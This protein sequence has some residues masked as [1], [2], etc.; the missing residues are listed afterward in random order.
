MILGHRF[1]LYDR[2][3]L[4]ESI[5]AEG[6]SGVIR[7]TRSIFILTFVIELL[8]AILLSVSFVPLYGWAKGI[9]YAVFHSVSAFCNAGFD[10]I[11][12]SS[13]I[14]LKENFTLMLPLM[15]LIIIGGLGFIVLIEIK[16]Q[17]FKKLSL[18]SKVVLLMTLILIL[19]GTLFF[20]NESHNPETIV[21][22][23]FMD[24]LEI[25][26]FQSVTTRTAGFASL[27]QSK[28]TPTSLLM[29]E[30][31]MFIGG[32]PGSTAG[33]IKTA[34]LALLIF[35]TISVIRGKEDTEIL[36]RRINKGSVNR[37]IAVLLMALAIL[38]IAI[39]LLGAFERHLPISAISYEVVSALGTVGL[40]TGITA[41]LS[42]PS[43]VVLIMCMFFGRVG[44]MT[45][46]FSLV[47]RSQGK[48][49]LL[50]PEGRIFIN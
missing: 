2:L 6:L 41:S 33:G 21:P 1:T 23:G 20:F 27:D 43:K 39:M 26:L 40:S 30:F 16:E 7:I 42:D 22:L 44:P 48:A 8:G 25:S 5:G 19:G 18:H 38:A 14:P 46:L 13:L 36:Q 15:L 10:L 45:V 9:Y 28:L 4:K 29:T 50:Y 47:R 32:S 17:G 34:T 12:S 11:G 31:L 35:T 3:I 49:N 24:R 37:A